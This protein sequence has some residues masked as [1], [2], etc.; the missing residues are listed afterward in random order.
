MKET[1]IDWLGTFWKVLTLPTPKTFLAEAKK[2]DGKFV[3]AV[4]WLVFL[5]IYLYIMAS[6][7]VD[8]T[9]LSVSILMTLALGIPCAVILATSTAHAICRRVFRRK[10]YLYDKMLYIVVAI[11]FPIF[12]IFSPLSIFIP[13]SVFAFLIFILLIYQ[14]ALLTIAITTIAGIEYWQGL[15]IVFLS[16]LVGILAFGTTFILIRATISPSSLPHSK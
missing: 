14:V 2:A 13:G 5:A 15:V 7:A 11:L 3:S 9:P 4:G 1:L 10:E 8:R 16:L 12:L 6:I